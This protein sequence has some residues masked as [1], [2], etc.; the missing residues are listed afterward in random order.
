MQIRV[1]FDQKYVQNVQLKLRFEPST[2][3]LYKWGTVEVVKSL[4][5]LAPLHQQTHT[6]L[7][8]L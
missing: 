7:Q 8:Q 5:M 4:F 3:G 2:S 1:K 6:L